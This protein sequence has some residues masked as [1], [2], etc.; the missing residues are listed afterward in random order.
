MNGEIGKKY[1]KDVN[2]HEY[3]VKQNVSRTDF[4][5]KECDDHFQN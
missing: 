4:C 5:Q 3:G 2:W 1:T